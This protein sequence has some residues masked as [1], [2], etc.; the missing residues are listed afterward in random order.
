MTRAIAFCLLG[1]FAGVALAD[2]STPL[3]VEVQRL[4]KSAGRHATSSRACVDGSGRVV[5]INKITIVEQ[6]VDAVDVTY[7]V[8]TQ[9]EGDTRQCNYAPGGCPS[10]TPVT[11]PQ[12]ATL[13]IEQRD[14][15]RY[16]GIPKSLPGIEAMGALDKVWSTGCYGSVGKFVPAPLK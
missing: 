6:R 8:T 16:L 14:G 15:K 9:R 1:W 12:R 3:P 11:T 13:T 10:R 4:F 5:T 2:K 7:E